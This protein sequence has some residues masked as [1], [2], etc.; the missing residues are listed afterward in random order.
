[1][2]YDN[3]TRLKIF[4]LDLK[5]DLEYNEYVYCQSL[6][7]PLIF[8]EKL[9]STFNVIKCSREYQ[10]W[11]RNWVSLSISKFLFLGHLIKI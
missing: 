10:G 4:N 11:V 3:E 6:R 2:G 1:M 5:L 8:N 7:I 9:E